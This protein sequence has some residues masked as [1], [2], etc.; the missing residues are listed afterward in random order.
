MRVINLLC[1]FPNEQPPSHEPSKLFRVTR[2]KRFRGLPHWEKRILRD[3]GLYERSGVAIVKNIPEN[4]ARLWKVKHLIRIEPI[5]FPHGEPT[6]NDINH[7]FLKE[8]GEC[9]VVKEIGQNFNKRIEAA[10]NIVKDPKRLTP[11]I[12]KDDSRKKWQKAWFE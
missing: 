8:S 2:I 12:L 5:T 7:T 9:I 6:E 10:K 4:N 1:R 11:E 3:M